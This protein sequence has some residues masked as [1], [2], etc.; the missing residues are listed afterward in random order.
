MPT[1]GTAATHTDAMPYWLASLDA[2]ALT[3]LMTRRPDVLVPLPST[4]VELA[5][6][7]S[8]P[9]SVRLAVQDFDRLRVDIL[10]AAQTLSG[11]VTADTVAGR[12]IPRADRSLV[13]DTLARLCELGLIWPVGD[14]FRLVAP[15][16]AAGVRGVGRMVLHLEP[17]TPRLASI[18]VDAIDE[19][20]GAAVLPTLQGVAQLIE[21]CSVTPLETL[22]SGGVGVKELRRVAKALGADDP[23]VRLWLALAYHAD[24][25]DADDGR[26]MPTSAADDWLAGTP[27]QRLVPLLMT[28]WRM[29][30]SPTVPDGN[31]K[32]PTALIHAYQD[33]DRET[34]QD[35]IG[36]LAAQQPG[37]ALVDRA[38]LLTL[39]SWRQPYDYGEPGA[40]D[41][42]AAAILAEAERLGVWAAEGIST[43]GRALMSDERVDL[44]AIVERVLP[45]PTG[46]VRLQA[47][48]TAVVGG[49]PTV[50]L[51]TLL[52]LAADAGERDTASV[53]RF[54]PTSVR[55]ALTAG[56]TAD[57]LLAELASMS[58]HTLPQPLE[59]L[60]RD[61]ARRH[62]ELTVAPVGC[63][64]LADDPALLT[65]VVAH[66]G[67][68]ELRA[69]LLAPGVLASAKSAPETLALLRKHGYAPVTV[70]DSGAPSLERVIPERARRRPRPTPVALPR[71]PAVVPPKSDLRALAAELLDDRI[72]DPDPSPHVYN[73]ALRQHG[74][75][76]SNQ[77]LALLFD[78]VVS[79]SPVRITYL[80]QSGRSSSRVITP[81]DIMGDLVEAWCHL[82][83]D[84]RHFLVSRI[85]RV[86]PVTS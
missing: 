17:P 54:S 50:E 44:A 63:C 8:S 15:L 66:R 31:G 46:T 58:A 77:E 80:D 67:L 72:V 9:S 30:A 69:R 40:M 70:D 33:H 81:L 64:V 26:I 20:A 23:T 84:E 4:L 21:L 6:R 65:E 22:R 51:G 27:S 13:A 57:R 18:G 79:E 45:P 59:Y 19:L 73:T 74:D 82:R 36:W 1:Q 32:L 25:V 56:Y 42:V 38:E 24:L 2:D 35:L 34:R 61:A 83:E 71:P 47:D 39:L 29:P 85:Q 49:I 78:A 55:R 16:R 68:T 28:W 52:D 12:F 48:L 53:W 43:W 11:E 37:A 60:V 3:E 86:D 75:H 7:L 5:D 62:G 76:L 41:D 10:A 14:S